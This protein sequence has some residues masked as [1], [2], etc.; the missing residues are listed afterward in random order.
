MAEILKGTM[1]SS[2]SSS[3]PTATLPNY[4]M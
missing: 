2:I 3:S 4:A 1:Y